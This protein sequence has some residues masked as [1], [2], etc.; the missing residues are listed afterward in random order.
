M[1]ASFFILR[2]EEG[3]KGEKPLVGSLKI[4]NALD[5]VC[6]GEHAPETRW[7]GVGLEQLLPVLFVLVQL[8]HR[9]LHQIVRRPPEAD[10][11]HVQLLVSA[12]G[13]GIYTNGCER[14]D[15][16]HGCSCERAD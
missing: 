8:V 1:K 13:Y 16:D 9:L 12:A 4:L 10:P 6:A 14:E 11:P 15:E 2:G 5:L 3:L 7:A